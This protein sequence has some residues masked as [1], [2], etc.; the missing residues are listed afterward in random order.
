MSADMWVLAI[1]SLA[2]GV[3]CGVLFTVLMLVPSRLWRRKP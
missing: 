2:L 1:C 3:T